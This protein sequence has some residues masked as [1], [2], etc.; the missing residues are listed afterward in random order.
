[1]QKARANV[2]ST[3]FGIAIAK[4]VYFLH[5]GNISPFSS[6]FD[7]FSSYFHPKLAMVD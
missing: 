7:A 3:A 1:M 6:N 5:N 4:S 2:Y